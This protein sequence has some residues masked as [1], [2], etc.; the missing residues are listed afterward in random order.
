M[1]HITYRVRKTTSLI[2][3]ELEVVLKEWACL[4]TSNHEDCKHVREAFTRVDHGESRLLVMFQEVAPSCEE[5][6][7]Q[8]LKKSTFSR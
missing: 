6:K 1:C 4:H 7:E 8:C 3:T 5:G 2:I